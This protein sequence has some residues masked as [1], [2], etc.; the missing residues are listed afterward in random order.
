M[1][2]SAG[3]LTTR[4]RGQPLLVL[5]GLLLGWIALRAAFWEQIAMP[6]LAAVTVV[7]A[8]ATTVPSSR[9]LAPVGLVAAADL[10][11]PPQARAQARVP[12]PGRPPA[13]AGAASLPILPPSA[14]FVPPAPYTALPAP[15]APPA[16]IAAPADQSV[17]RVAA[18]HQ[19]AW[20]AG[21]AQL[22][23]PLFVLERLGRDNPP[24]AATVARW[25]ADGW[26]LLRRGGAE[27]AF[28]GV[29]APSYGRSQFGAVLRYRLSP[30][31]PHRPTAFLRATAATEAPRGEELAAGVAVRPLATV[32]LALVAEARIAN[33]ATGRPV[34]P[35]VGVVSELPRLALPLRL[36]AETYVQ[37][38]LVG[39][40][41]GTPFIDGQVRAERSLGAIGPN[42]L[43]AGLAAWGG[44]Q[45][46]ANRIDFGPTATFDFRV[47][48]GRGRLSADWRL[49][50]AG[51][52]APRS[53][54]AITLSAGF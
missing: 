1:T 9:P 47:G 20:M 30:A 4:R 13:S 51:N 24:P 35:A 14:A 48:P 53:G 15:E 2:R 31:S 16:S 29:A 34:R 43:R 18:G 6:P 17:V 37:A 40:A 50:A 28:G 36:S 5:G 38:G 19:L 42:E 7:Q 44:A 23:M 12:V 41:D 27:P 11:A 8:A 49:R 21:V 33:R 46:G 52:A 54:P 26:L 3:A 10:P 32:P 22:P 39:G 45:K 25:S